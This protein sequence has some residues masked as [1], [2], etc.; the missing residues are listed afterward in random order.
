[1]NP[2]ERPNKVKANLVALSTAALL[3]VYAAGYARTRPAAQR[4][5]AEDTTQR[6]GVS[7]APKSVHADAT[8]PAAPLPAEVPSQP[9]APTPKVAAR[10][11]TAAPTPGAV[12]ATKTDSTVP[13]LA[14]TEPPPVVDSA[15]L[16]VTGQ[17]V[18][19][20]APAVDKPRAGL[21][22][23]IYTGWGTSRHGDI[24]A[25]VEIKNGR[26]L[27]ASITQCLTRYSCS[28]IAALPGQIIARQ[29]ADVDLVSGATQS[30]NAFY[31]AIV[32][33]L[34]KAK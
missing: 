16:P 30:T 8:P 1:V 33:A 9:A 28:W 24:E 19:S 2:D 3:T 27:T 22:D 13:V 4:F 31:D 10:T 7:G 25:S 6:P 15:R 34:A 23:G 20:A 17:A 5:A 32:E 26:I 18:D 14:V 21:K 29:R 11:V 12:A